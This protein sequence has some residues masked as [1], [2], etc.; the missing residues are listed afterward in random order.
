MATYLERVQKLKQFIDEREVRKELHSESE[1]RPSTRNP[2]DYV[3][4]EKLKGRLQ[5]AVSNWTMPKEAD[6]A[7]HRWMQGKTHSR[8]SDWVEPAEQEFTRIMGFKP[9]NLET[10]GKKLKQQQK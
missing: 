7:L 3:Y 10:L 9:Q 4:V 5:W 8:L 2:A 6:T 1:R